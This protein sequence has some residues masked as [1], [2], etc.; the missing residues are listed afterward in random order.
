MKKSQYSK[1]EKT[2]YVSNGNIEREKISK[3]EKF[4]IMLIKGNTI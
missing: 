2:G 1:K 3:S 4:K